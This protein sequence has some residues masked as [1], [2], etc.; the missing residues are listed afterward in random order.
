MTYPLWP[1]VAFDLLLVVIC[2]LTLRPAYSTPY[3]IKKDNRIF[4][5]LVFFIFCI[6]AFYDADFFHYKNAFQGMDWSTLHFEKVYYPIMSFCKGNYY[7]FRT[8]IWGGSLLLVYKAIKNFSPPID[9]TLLC[10]VVMCVSKFAYGRISL[11]QSIGLFG[12]SIIFKTGLKSIFKIIIGLLVVYLSSFFHSSMVY[13]IIMAIIAMLTVNLGKKSIV[14]I[15]CLYPFIVYY[16]QSIGGG[17]IEQLFS[18]DDM[19]SAAARYYLESDFRGYEGLT[20]IIQAIFER[21][22]VVLLS[23]L[24]CVCRWRKEHQEWPMY[25]KVLSNIVSFVAISSSVFSFNTTVNTY[26]LFYRFFNFSLLPS[27]VVLSYFLYN[28]IHYRYAN[29]I[30]KFSLI[31]SIYIMLLYTVHSYTGHLVFN[32]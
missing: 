17:L 22:P 6:F 32:I 10:F 4:V 19:T 9:L 7:V 23:I 31:G 24:I 8:I 18:S 11:A 12:L 26:T 28:R 25:V 1:F 30:F 27:M 5:L 16:F 2:I 20:M 3:T 21:G 13:G 14:F 29:F 15:L